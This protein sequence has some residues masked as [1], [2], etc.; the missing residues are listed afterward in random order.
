MNMYSNIVAGGQK[1]CMLFPVPVAFS[2]IAYWIETPLTCVRLVEVFS[3]HQL[4]AKELWVKHLYVSWKLSCCSFRKKLVCICASLAGLTL[5]C[6]NPLL[7]TNY[8]YLSL[9]RQPQWWCV[10]PVSG[11]VLFWGARINFTDRLTDMSCALFMEI[12]LIIYHVEK[13]I[14]Y[15]L[16]FQ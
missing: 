5:T 11:A 1:S 8:Q 7:I 4:C 2:Q 16:F 10:R 9:T 3:S 15:C 13:C 14:I 12:W 6:F